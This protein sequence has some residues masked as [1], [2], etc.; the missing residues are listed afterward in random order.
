MLVTNSRQKQNCQLCWHRSEL[1]ISSQQSAIG[2]DISR[3]NL[4]SLGVFHGEVIRY[5]RRFNRPPIA[6]REEHLC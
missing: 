2:Q 3:N 4:S 6:I 5:K 1:A